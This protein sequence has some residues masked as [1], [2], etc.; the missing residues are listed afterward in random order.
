VVRRTQAPRAYAACLAGLAERHMEHKAGALSLGARAK[1]LTLSAFERRPEL[2]RRV[3][4][5]LVRRSAIDPTVSRALVG[6]VGCALVVGAVALARC[7]QL[8]AFVPAEPKVKV[9]T[10]QLVPEQLRGDKVIAPAASHFRA[11]NAMAIM[12]E[13]TQQRSSHCQT[14]LTKA[15]YRASLRAS[16]LNYRQTLVNAQAN[17]ARQDSVADAVNSDTPIPQEL[18]VLTAYEQV[19]AAGDELG[20]RVVSDN[21]PNTTARPVDGSTGRVTVTRLIFRVYAPTAGARESD[22]PNGSALPSGSY[23]VSAQKQPRAIT[24]SATS[25]AAV[26]STNGTMD[27]PSGP[28][29][30]KLASHAAQPDANSIDANSLT[31]QPHAVALGNGWFVIQL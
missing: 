31:G 22:G 17:S 21:G 15:A 19:Q 23:T 3:H 9:E 16:E 30:G 10:A 4:S 27:K 20:D 5:I 24:T 8:V 18:I 13:T 29:A 11:V 14:G 6:A 2:A 25:A 12:P 26:Q 1:A 28:N 7:P